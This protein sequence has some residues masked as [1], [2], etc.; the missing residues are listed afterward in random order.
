MPASST[1]SW[2]KRLKSGPASRPGAK[3]TCACHSSEPG[4]HRQP[5]AAP[6]RA[7]SNAWKHGVLIGRSGAWL[8]YGDPER[9][10]DLRRFRERLWCPEQSRGALDVH[11]GA[12][13]SR[14]P[15]SACAASAVG[16]SPRAASSLP[17]K[18][19][20]VA[21]PSVAPP[22]RP[23]GAFIRSSARPAPSSSPAS[24]QH[25][26]T[27][28]RPASQLGL[29]YPSSKEAGVPRRPARMAHAGL[30]RRAQSW[31]AAP[32]ISA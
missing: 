18:R 3:S 30:G 31:R 4:R 13:L 8:E 19:A 20:Q 5:D 25:S 7:S 24:S 22:S 6:Q 23:A 15:A 11:Q 21:R 9:A 26:N 32:M 12:R 16:S 17:A 27:V 29:E 2:T 1:T 28:S 14:K 10:V